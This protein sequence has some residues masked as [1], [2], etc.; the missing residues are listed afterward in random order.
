MKIMAIIMDPEMVYIVRC[1]DNSTEIFM[2]KD[3]GTIVHKR[4]NIRFIRN[5]SS[6]DNVVSKEQRRTYEVENIVNPGSISRSGYIFKGWATT[7]GSST[8]MTFPQTVPSTYDFQDFVDYGY[9]IWEAAAATTAK[10]TVGTPVCMVKDGTNF[11]TVLVTNNDSSSVTI[12][13]YSNTIGTLGPGSTDSLNLQSPITLIHD[14]TYS[15]TATAMGKSESNPV[16][17]TGSIKV[18]VGEL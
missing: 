14:Y 6:N 11:L 7:R 15:I 3:N 5:H 17:G 10:P 4:P 8:P 9:A 18:C 12:K 1:Y 2:L 16:F 13:N